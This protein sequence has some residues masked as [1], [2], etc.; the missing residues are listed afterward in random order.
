M[1]DAYGFFLENPTQRTY[2]PNPRSE[3]MQDYDSHYRFIGMIV[4]KALQKGILL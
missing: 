4:G 2:Y 3:E 1:K